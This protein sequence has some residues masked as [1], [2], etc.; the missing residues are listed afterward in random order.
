SRRRLR[1][2]PRGGRQRDL[3]GPAERRSAGAHAELDREACEREHGRSAYPRPDPRREED[4][5]TT[6][7]AAAEPVAFA[8][9]PARDRAR[10]AQGE[11]RDDREDRDR[12]DTLPCG[13]ARERGSTFGG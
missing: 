11:Q 3:A 1:R 7:A 5:P 9:P 6:R 13:R 8:L 4:R 10:G 2:D 12:P